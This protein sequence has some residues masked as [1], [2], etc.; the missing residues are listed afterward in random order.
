MIDPSS[1]VDGTPN[2]DHLRNII[3]E[4]VRASFVAMLPVYL[5]PILTNAIKEQFKSIAGIEAILERHASAMSQGSAEIR[6]SFLA[7]RTLY[8]RELA[9]ITETHLKRFQD[10]VANA[11]DT[12]LVMYQN[13]ISSV[14]EHSLQAY[15]Q[16][17]AEPR[18]ARLIRMEQELRSLRRLNYSLLLI[19]GGIG[20]IYLWRNRDNS[21]GLIN[22]LSRNG[23]HI[24]NKVNSWVKHLIN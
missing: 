15:L 5:P 16:S 13:G 21:R 12:N 6:S 19:G 11:I 2:I 9:E 22:T 20:A 17:L 14:S 7:S 8:Q 23:I 24:W 4:Q 18:N 10:Q 1:E 3:T